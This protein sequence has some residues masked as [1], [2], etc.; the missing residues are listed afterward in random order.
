MDEQVSRKAPRTLS[1]RLDATVR[2]LAAG[3]VGD[4]AAVQHEARRILEMFEKG[5]DCG[6]R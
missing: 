5:S 2:D 4:A 3:R 1:E 6:S